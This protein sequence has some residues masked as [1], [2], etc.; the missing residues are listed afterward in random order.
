MEEAEE[1]DL[2]IDDKIPATL[3]NHHD[4]LSRSFLIVIHGFGENRRDALS[5]F[6][7]AFERGFNI[8]A[9]DAREHG[10]RKG[11]DLLKM[12]VGNPFLFTNMLTGTAE[13]VSIVIDYLTSNFSVKK[14]I[15]AGVSMGGMITYIAISREK[16]INA[17]VSIIAG[18]ISELLNQGSRIKS[19]L[20]IRTDLIDLTSSE[21]KKMLNK[22]DVLAFT[23]KCPPTP[24]LIL[25]GEADNIVPLFSIRKAYESLTPAY[26]KVGASYN[27]KMITY[28]GVKHKVTN[29]MIVDVLQWLLSKVPPT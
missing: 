5:L 21:I 1:W 19:E 3:V 11:T 29:K 13:D 4:K 15:L 18:S 8:I 20:K 2:I 9:I 23:E 16:R 27:L 22:V 24:L 17:A 7:T 6:R 26:E 14:F 28:P 25:A 10:D 12:V